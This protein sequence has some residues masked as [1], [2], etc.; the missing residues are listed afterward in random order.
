[1]RFGVLQQ[2]LAMAAARLL[3]GALLLAGLA[4]TAFAAQTGEPM[5]YIY[6][7]PESADDHRYEYHWEILKA[8]LEKTRDRFGPYVMRPS[9]VM[10]ET[11]QMH[12][13]KR[14]AGVINVVIRDTAPD[15]EKNLRPIRIPIDKGLLGYRVF[16]IRAEDQP[17]FSAVTNIAALKKFSIGQGADWGDVAILK[18]SGF[19]VVTD[20]TYEGLFRMLNEHFFDA[21]SR[22]VTE[23]TDE[24]DTRKP[25]YPNMEI[26]RDLMIYYPL[27]TYFWFSK[28]KDGEKLAQRAELGM[29]EMIRDGEYEAIFRKYHDAVIQH[30]HLK[31]RRLFRI[32]NPTL[33]ATTPYDDKSLWYDPLS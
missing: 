30:L 31:R 24:Y 28:S 5:V 19:K 20:V 2:R 3:A 33:P 12:E 21:F 25:Q 9:P 7:P 22:G 32:E 16:L 26:E 13:L 1:M 29:R 15:Y 8:A 27:P 23:V 4:G 11:R 14:N 17:K 18:H 10:N 6:H